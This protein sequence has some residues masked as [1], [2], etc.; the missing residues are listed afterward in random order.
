M[1]LTALGLGCTTA[2]LMSCAAVGGR[3][4]LPAE[5]NTSYRQELGPTVH[6]FSARE[7]SP[8]AAS[9]PGHQFITQARQALLGTINDVERPQVGL[10]DS[11]RRLTHNKSLSG[12]ANGVFTRHIDYGSN[13]MQWIHGALGGVTTL[14]DAAW[15]VDEPDMGLALLRLTGPRLQAAMSGATLLAAWVD[16]LNLA[17]AVLRQCPSYGTERLYANMN[18]AQRLIEPSMRALSSLEP[19]QVG[20]ATVAM[21]A[22]MGQLTREFHS[23]REG[24]HV[25]SER[26]GQ[27]MAAAQ[28][29]EMITLISTMKMS[30][31]RLPPAAPATL[32]VGLV[33]GANGVMMGSQVVV[34]AEWIELMRRLVQAGVLSAAAV[35][36]IVRIH[37]GQVMM[38][39]A[40][41]GLPQGVRDALGDGPEVR[42][43]HETGKAGA[44][45]AEPPR[46]HVL[47]DE[48]RKWFEQRGFTGAMDIDQFCVKLEA[49]NHQA[50]HGGGNWRLGRTWAG[51]W[52]RMIM[53]VL[54]GAEAA[55]G[56]RLTR[57]EILNIVAENMKEYR[58]PM[59]FVSGRGR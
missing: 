57:D 18:R 6:R 26:A 59:N 7:S 29:V 39:Q 8:P 41:Q 51:E 37:A 33:M 22:L 55:V 12:R 20:E 21:P 42:G 45:M 28:A 5:A 40:H 16:F 11:L 19:A 47:P 3:T 56:R 38:S 34:T 23:I 27:L 36:A 43:M 35:S 15:E 14:A 50:I 31:P 4:G 58:I 17:D 53:R 1:K 49:A 30:L 46:H 54:R 44:G 13:Q 2:L 52:N 9:K 25:A 32:S 10:A 48:H 24:A